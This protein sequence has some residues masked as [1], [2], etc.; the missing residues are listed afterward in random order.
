MNIKL[1]LSFDGSNYHGWQRQENAMTV[2]QKMEEAIKKLTGQNSAVI[3]CSRTDAGV[4][5]IKYVC[6]FYSDTKIPINKIPIAL[7]TVLPR[8]IRINY[9]EYVDDSFHARFSA[10]SKTYLYLIWNDPISIPFLARYSYHF[11][12][13]LDTDK[14]SKAAKELVGEHDFS[15]FM[16]TGGSQKSTIRRINYLTVNKDGSKI[17]IEINANAYLYNMV[18]IIAGTLIYVGCGKLSENDIKRIMDSKN[19]VE[20]GIT[21]PPHGLFLKDIF[22]D[23]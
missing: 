20:A 15:A 9:A 1:C 23:E 4:H 7:N 2:Q 17:S 16:A 11:P 12:L 21:A 8:D 6:N 5:A 19:R 3:G 13:K 14:M 10:K 22:F 18:R